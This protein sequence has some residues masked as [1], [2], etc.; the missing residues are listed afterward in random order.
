MIRFLD[1][2]RGGL[3]AL[4]LVFTAAVAIATTTL[5]PQAFDGGS[6][7]DGI[8]IGSFK[9]FPAATNAELK[10]STFCSSYPAVRCFAYNLDEDDVYTS[11]STTGWRSLT[12]GLA[13]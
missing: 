2:V 10:T 9:I 1:H 8:Q 3:V 6:F 13:P 12:H 7:V 4:A 11:T 5:N